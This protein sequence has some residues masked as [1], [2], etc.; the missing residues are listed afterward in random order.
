MFS[1]SLTRQRKGQAFIEFVII[2]TLLVGIGF[3]LFTETRNQ[4]G[5]SWQQTT[6]AISSG[7]SNC[8]ADV[9]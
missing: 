4:I 8:P 3:F 5:E 1:H 2:L 7:C 9:N 6:E